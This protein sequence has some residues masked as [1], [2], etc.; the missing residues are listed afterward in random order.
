MGYFSKGIAKNYQAHLF[1]KGIFK[2]EIDICIGVTS[3]RQ[4]LDLSYLHS[5]WNTMSSFSI[6]KWE[7]NINN[8]IRVLLVHIS[9]KI[10]YV[11]LKL[12]YEDNLLHDEFHSLHNNHSSCLKNFFLATFILNIEVDCTLLFV[13][14]KSCQRGKQF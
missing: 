12:H 5:S 10:L 11:L 7:P 1:G 4:N 6:S 3:N 8:K 9:V 13:L 14:P 2:I